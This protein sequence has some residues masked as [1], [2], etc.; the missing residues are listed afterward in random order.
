MILVQTPPGSPQT[1]VVT[2]ASKVGKGL[3][4]VGSGYTEGGGCY[5]ALTETMYTS[6]LTIDIYN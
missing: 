3:A 4:N 1:K 2:L 6:T 5:V